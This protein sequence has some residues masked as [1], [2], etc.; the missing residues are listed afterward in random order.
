MTVICYHL[1]KRCCACE[2]QT[3]SSVAS[4][5]IKTCTA[6]WKSVKRTTPTKPRVIFTCEIQVAFLQCQVMADV[7]QEMSPVL[8]PGYVFF[9]IFIFFSQIVLILNIHSTHLVLSA[10]S[11]LHL[12]IVMIYNPTILCPRRGWVPIGICFLPRFLSIISENVSLPLFALACSF[13]FTRR[14]L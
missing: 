12:H 13:T 3:N 14:H 4:G 5:K 7:Q 6:T 10:F 11:F 2:N 1:W 8:I 9:V